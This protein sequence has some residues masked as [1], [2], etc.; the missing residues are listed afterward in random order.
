MI[1]EMSILARMGPEN[2]ECAEIIKCVYNLSD[3][4][5]K[6]LDSLLDDEGIRASDVAEKIGKDRSTAH[7]SLEK[8]VACGMCSKE[9][10]AGHPRGFANYYQRIPNQEL[11]KKT[12][13][14]LDACYRNVKKILKEL[15]E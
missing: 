15:D 4:D 3:T 11:L 5:V 7:R 12:E 10:R 9:R 13:Q 1:E 8:L 2:M 6:A 14:K